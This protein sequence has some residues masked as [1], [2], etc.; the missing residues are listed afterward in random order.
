[1]LKI[2]LFAVLW[3]MRH[4]RKAWFVITTSTIN[5]HWLRSIQ[6]SLA[7]IHF[8]LHPT[9][10][11]ALLFI[12]ISLSYRARCRTQQ[13]LFPPSNRLL[14]CA[15]KI[16]SHLISYTRISFVSRSRQKR[17]LKIT[18]SIGGACSTHSWHSN[19]MRLAKIRIFLSAEK[20]VLTQKVLF[21]LFSP[22]HF[23]S[24]WLWIRLAMEWRKKTSARGKANIFFPSKHRKRKKKL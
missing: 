20:R 24:P 10:A 13:M 3:A 21:F 23:F 19:R 4:A 12:V 16:S 15:K 8:L 14:C 17:V 22:S 6:F 5:F 2:V 11:I 1:M 7:N 18:V 9:K